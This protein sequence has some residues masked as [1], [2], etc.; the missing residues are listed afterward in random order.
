MKIFVGLMLMMIAVICG[1][2][3][4]ILTIV[5]LGIGG[6]FTI[7]GLIVATIICGFFG[8]AILND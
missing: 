2:A 3:S 6:S 8:L 7:I 5:W 4:L 1:V